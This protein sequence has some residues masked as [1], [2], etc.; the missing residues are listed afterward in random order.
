MSEKIVR[1]YSKDFNQTPLQR[2]LII[3][4][5][6]TWNDENGHQ[7]SGLIT[8]IVRLF[9]SLGED[10]PT[11]IAR[12]FRGVGNDDDCTALERASGG[13]IGGGEKRIRCH[14]YATLVKE[15]QPGDRILIFG[16]SRG[17]ACARMLASQLHKEGI[18]EKIT[19]TTESYSNRSTRNIEQRFV[20]YK[21]SGGIRPV[22]VDF[23]GVWD[24][25][26]AFGVPVKLL[27]IPFHKVNLFKDMHVSPNV[28]KA[29]HLVALDETRDPY[30]PTLMNQREGIHEVWFP[31]VH[32]DVGGSYSED[33]LASI[34]LDYMV[35]QLKSLSADANPIHINF[36]PAQ[37]NEYIGN[38]PD[39]DYVFHF[40]GLGYKKSLRTVFVQVDDQPAEAL[41]PKIHESVL[42][43][44][45]SRKSYSLIENKNWFK[46]DTKH[47]VRIQYQP[48]NIKTLKNGYEIID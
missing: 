17:A 4:M 9:K 3:L 1:E 28:Q 11:Q 22:S 31:G 15:W 46:A 18:P 7:G 44:Q 27:G 30:T 14:A 13:A 36:N 39:D 33:R 43:I 21:S 6:G 40:H 19:I 48:A 45:D 29:V 24:T 37:L 32:S 25:V 2:N 34:T 20:K 8:N 5:D 47:R 26:G 41:R 38:L 12:Y 42:R 35:N 16:F 23:L 10:S